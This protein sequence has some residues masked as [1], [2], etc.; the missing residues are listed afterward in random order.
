MWVDNVAFEDL[1]EVESVVVTPPEGRVR[2]TSTNYYSVDRH[3]YPETR[4]LRT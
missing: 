3:V 1:V 4:P 2:Q